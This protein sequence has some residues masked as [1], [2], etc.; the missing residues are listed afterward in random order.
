MSKN[1]VKVRRISQ[2]DVKNQAFNTPD[3]MVYAFD[4]GARY[5]GRE[6][7]GLDALVT[8][9]IGADGVEFSVGGEQP[10]I[11]ISPVEPSDPVPGTVWIQT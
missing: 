9:K 6:D 10:G 8:A 1:N 5:M 3:E 4:T 11:I 2:S 7:G